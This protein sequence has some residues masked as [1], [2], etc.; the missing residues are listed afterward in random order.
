MQF[1]EREKSILDSTRAK[2]VLHLGCIGF[3]NTEPTERV[4]LFKQSLHYRL[5]ENADVVGIDYAQSV[6]DLLQQ[7]GLGQNI[8][9]GNV[10]K[11]D[12]V[13]VDGVF[14][15]IVVGDIIE[16]IANPGKMLAGIKRFCGPSTEILITTPN[17]FGIM[18]NIRYTF[19]RYR[20]SLDHVMTFNEYH[21]QQLLDWYGFSISSIDTCYQSRTDGEHNAAA[22][23]IA[24]MLF[25]AVPKW[26]GTLFIRAKLD[27][28]TT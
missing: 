21:V 6:I 25:R 17:A 28:E 19:G 23:A 4:G 9:F 22:L 26:G 1:F 10:E 27:P 16:H 7:D 2:R 5:S 8:L 15:V 18:G 14:D 20:E 12:E 3:T 11:L 13:E 24:K